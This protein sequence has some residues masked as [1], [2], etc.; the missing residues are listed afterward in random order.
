MVTANP[1]MLVDE[2][3]VNG[4][5]PPSES[6]LQQYEKMIVTTLLRSFALDFMFN[7]Q[8][9]GNIDTPLTARKYGL[10]D[11]DAVNRFENRGIYKDNKDAYHRHEN[12]R[13][14]N[15]EASKLRDA[16][17]LKDTYSD[18]K[19]GLNKSYDL[20]HTIAAKEIHDDP[21]IYLT[22]LDGVDLANADS[23]LNH[24][25]SSINRS[26]KQK[27]MKQFVFELQQK[28]AETNT[29]I[30][31]LKN[32]ENLSDKERK[33]LNKLENLN[34]INAEKM[35]EVDKEAR[36]VYNKSITQA[37]LKD[38]KTWEKLGK[39]ST[40]QGVKMGTRQVLGVLLSEVWMIVRRRFPILIE[41]MK[42]NFSL[43]VFLEQV[44]EAF[45][46]AFEMVKK[47]FR[48]LIETFANGFLAGIL[49]SLSTFLLNFFAGTAKSVVK[50][51]R[52]FWGSVTEIF[53]FL[54]FNKD[55]LSS[56]ELMRSISKIIIL[57]AS[58]VVGT[59]VSEAFSKLPVAQM[60][61]IGE[62]LTIFIGGITTGIISISL[63]YFIDHSKKVAQLVSYL[64]K[65][66]D[67]ID[68]KHQFYTD[69]NMKLKQKVSEL[70][71][72]PLDELNDQILQVSN[73]TTSLKLATTL[74]EKNKIVT[75]AIHS[76]NLDLPYED[77]DGLKTLM[78]DKTKTLTF[79]LGL[80]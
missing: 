78:R 3:P 42:E 23:N 51:I 46:E 53:N 74:D 43:K 41:N 77:I 67:Q 30:N 24:T 9:G 64:N 1:L 32:R 31:E 48:V 59:F 8:D 10:K 49:S 25:N 50:V 62:A 7:D 18:E 20:D 13:L 60:P 44:G 63:V 19:I 75:R 55:N 76:M 6:L 29:K 80:K 61:V 26:K 38:K 73:M 79:G 37:Y 72:I 56:E 57:A 27:E 52:E 71:S 54:V 68:L 45:K 35:L 4:D 70:A 58:V 33:E 15:R 16:G 34:K 65:F 11:E 69:L 14:K 21:A 40:K 17:E 22:N 66:T 12:Y 5:L 36:K 2:V 28:Q 47:K 39:D